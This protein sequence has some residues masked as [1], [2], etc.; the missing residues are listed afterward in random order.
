MKKSLEGIRILDLTNY[1][2]GPFCTQI[3]GGLGAEII[4]IERPKVGDPVRHMPPFAG[5]DGIAYSRKNADDMTMGMLKRGRNKKSVTLNLKSTRGKEIFLE[6][7]EKSQVVMENFRPGVMEDLGLGFDILKKANPA[8]VLGRISGFGQSSPYSH[9]PAFDLVVQAFSGTMAVTGYP[10]TPPCRTGF[11]AGDLMASLHA[12]IGVLSAIRFS[13]KTGQGQVVDISMLD[14]LVSLLFDE[15]LDF[16]DKNNIPMRTGNDRPRLAPFNCYETQDGYFVIATGSDLHWKRIAKAMGREELGDDPK[17]SKMEAR[18][19]NVA[20]L[21]TLIEEWAKTKSKAEAV[22]ILQKEE[23]PCG[24]VREI[25]EIYKD[26]E[27]KNRG[28]FSPLRHP[29]YGEVE[30]FVAPGIP[31][32]MSA[33]PPSLEN[34][35]PLLGEHNKDV[36]NGLLGYSP[37]KIASLKAEGVI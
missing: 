31:I 9:L 19:E 2:S 7:A 37:E 24:P 33:S 10:S 36:Y 27:L 3:L 22:S 6:L 1:L 5:K 29:V 16:F 4:K 28:M 14:G 15:P 26:E 34:D 17:F 30:D 25:D 23:V 18:M 8:M 32:G 11:A 21:N 35:A 12:T 20:E 13:E